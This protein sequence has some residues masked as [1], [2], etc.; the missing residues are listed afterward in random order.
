MRYEAKRTAMAELSDHDYRT[1]ADFRQT[2]RGFFH[3]SEEAAE[4]VGLTAQQHQALLAIKAADGLTVGDLAVR[5]LVRP[6]SATGLANRLERL[7]YITR[8]PAVG[9]RRQVDLVVTELAEALLR[10]LSAAHR[11]ELRR[12]GPMLTELLGRL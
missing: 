6:H 9:D 3:F 2:L 4:A 7:G 10:S 12:L 5:L 8:V 11:A 1:L